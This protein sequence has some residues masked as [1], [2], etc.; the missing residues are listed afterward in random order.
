MDNHAFF[1][2]LESRPAITRSIALLVVASFLGLY[3]VPTVAAAREAADRAALERSLQ[4]VGFQAMEQTVKQLRET[5]VVLRTHWDDPEQR[6]SIAAAMERLDRLHDRLAHQHEQALKREQQVAEKL[7]RG[8]VPERIQQRYRRSQDRYVERLQQALSALRVL[9]E[10]DP[11]H[12]Q[13][14]AVE[15]AFAALAPED[16]PDFQPALQPEHR[17]DRDRLPSRAVEP[18]DR[19]AP[20]MTPEEFRDDGVSSRPWPRLAAHGDFRL[21]ELTGADEPRW[22]ETTTEVK[23]TDAIEGKA[24]ELDHDP[25]R[26]HNWVRNNVAWI[27][28]W[29]AMQDAEHTL[30]ARQGN[31]FDIAS[32]QIALLRASGVPARYVH[33]T[34]DVEADRF[35]NWAGGFDDVS[36]AVDHAA[37]GG[38]PITSRVSGGEIASVRMEHIWV[39]AALDYFPSRAAVMEA[40]DAW[41]PLDAAFKQYEFHQRIDVTEVTGIDPVAVA[42]QFLA[43]GNVEENAGYIQ[44]FDA[45][46]LQATQSDAETALETHIDQLPDDATVRDVL[47]GREIIARDVDTLPA[48]IPNA[49]QTV[50]ARYDALPE[51]LQHRI[52]FG[53]G[54]GVFG[55]LR[56]AVEFAWPEVNGER[57]TLAFSPATADDEAALEA[58]LPEGEI[59]DAE[60]LP[61]S[62]PTSLVNVV[63]ELRVD[64]EVVSSGAP[65]GVGEEM[66]F[67]FTVN[68]RGIGP[69]TERKAVVAG[70]YL[71]IAVAGGS[72]SPDRLEHVQQ[73]AERTTGAL[74][75]EDEQQLASLTREDL[76]GDLFHAGML[77]YFAQLQ[78]LSQQ[79]V[80]EASAQIH[81]APSAGT[82]GYTPNVS[83]L[84]GLPRA[85]SPGGV[86]MDLDRIAR[87]LSVPEAPERDRAPLN[88][89]IGALSSALE[90]AVPEQQF[91]TESESAEGISAAKALAIANDEGQ[92]IYNIDQSNRDEALDQLNLSSSVRSEIRSAVNAGLVVTTHTDPVTVLG[93]QGAGYV[94]LDPETGSG[95]WLIE[96]SLNGG[97]LD[98][99]DLVTSVISVFQ[100]AAEGIARAIDSSSLIARGLQEAG[101]ALALLGG[102]LSAIDVYDATGSL[103]KSLIAGIVTIIV[104]VAL[105]VLV[106]EIIILAALIGIAGVALSLLAVSIGFAA[107][108]LSSFVSTILSKVIK[109][110][111]E[112]IVHKIADKLRSPGMP[113]DKRMPS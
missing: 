60:D 103:L 79:Q 19:R 80:R 41:V 76:L 71:H 12:A 104:T 89:Q 3:A 58:L 81:L 6:E 10:A 48:R 94:I 55:E 64:G 33:G 11:Q 74:D 73:R 69:Q 61:S 56:N 38:I 50:G 22:L 109:S 113:V 8:N 36:R 99:E 26:I 25:V 102:I 105:A 52:T 83:N 107:I 34:I 15:A 59:E 16:E 31:A 62:I 27:P 92:R 88:T 91:S 49:V 87:T 43:S 85:I 51:A 96:G 78:V 37:S 97:F 28:S 67:A 13:P 68:Q 106:T 35:R 66:D 23:I 98:I 17:F 70:S 20:R 39:E 29:A 57:V 21:D 42:Q 4:P 63:P 44:G 93:W 100:T 82:Y 72:V 77:A 5:L 14:A 9:T 95:A 30:S 2:W 46:I 101:R 111:A 1:A 45:G 84:F 54:T 108:V 112:N 53:L 110:A 7:Q 86:T 75:S 24:A 40:A 18:K 32:L 47:G 65:L 90:H